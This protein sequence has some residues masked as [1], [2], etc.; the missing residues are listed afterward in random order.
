MGCTIS[1]RPGPCAG[2]VHLVRGVMGTH[3]RLLDREVTVTYTGGTWA[4]CAFG[5]I[6]P[7]VSSVVRKDPVPSESTRELVIMVFT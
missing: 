5:D 6:L 7:S 1:L 2:L 3:T 4:S